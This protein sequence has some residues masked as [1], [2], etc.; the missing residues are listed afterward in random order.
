MQLKSS[1]TKV[2]K[3]PAPKVPSVFYTFRHKIYIFALRLK[4]YQ[5]TTLKNMDLQNITLHTENGICTVTINR[6]DKLNALNLKTM[7][8]IEEIMDE[9]Y[10]NPQIKGVIITGAGEKAFV[11]GADIS[12]FANINPISARKFAERGQEIFAS[13]A[14]CHK[15]VLA[16]INGFALGGGCELAMACHL[17][18]ASENAKLGLPEVSLG[19]IPGFGGTQRL[20]QLVGAGKAFEMMMTGDM[21]DAQEAHRIGLVNHVVPQTE[22]QAKAEKIIAKIITRSPLAVGQLIVCVHAAGTPAGFQTEANAF[23]NCCK[24]EDFQEGTTAFMEKRKPNFQGK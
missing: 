2:F 4:T 3:C 14:N 23:G 20:P 7:D 1:R 21:I 22:L 6:P 18:I 19:L 9:V 8:E 16:A 11:A 5:V 13:V 15:P 12:E 10:D 24:T 17:R